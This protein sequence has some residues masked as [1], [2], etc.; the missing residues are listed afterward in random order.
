[1]VDFMQ[2]TA[3]VDTNELDGFRIAELIA[4]GQFAFAWS[5]DPVSITRIAQ[6]AF[7]AG[8]HHSRNLQDFRVDAK[9]RR[10]GLAIHQED[11]SVNADLI[12]ADSQ[13]V[14]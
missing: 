4:V 10:M 12:G 11:A 5:I 9:Q 1:M 13:S 14:I 6:A 2:C 8:R 7:V 3:C